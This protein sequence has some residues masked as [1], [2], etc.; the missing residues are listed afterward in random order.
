[1]HIL[2]I[3]QYFPPEM[4]A[5]AARAYEF[6]RRWVE[7]GHRVTVLCGVPNHPTGEV[8]PGYRQQWRRQETI[9][10]IEVHRMWVYVTANAGTLRRTLNY[11]SFGLTS[12][13][14]SLRIDA[15]DVCIAS[16]PQFFAGLAGTVVRR[17]KHIPLVLEVRDLW[18]DSIAA[19]DAAAGKRTMAL[20]RRIERFMYRS[21]QRIVIVSPAFRAHIERCGIPGERIDVIPNGVNTALF[22]PRAGERRHFSAFTKRF[23]VGYIGT[24]GLAHGLES[25]LAA[26]KLLSNEN[27]HFVLVGEGARKAELKRRA[28]R[29]HN[30]TFYDRRPRETVAEM[31]AELD[32][33]LVLL[34]D[35]PLFQTVI[36]SK[37]FEIMGSGIPLILGVDGQAREILDAADGGIAIPPENP[38]ALAHAILRLRDDTALRE[39][40]G[41]N[42]YRHVRE[43]YDIDVLAQKY[44][45][46]LQYACSDR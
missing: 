21:A 10:G 18:P 14:G 17:L 39:K 8:Y 20:L 32:A 29:M 26:A 45:T 13:L 4:G 46:T 44:L 7:A 27:V 11:L 35:I 37:M 22:Y 24:H 38:E 9:D 36:P 41:K 3:C 6:S 40:A 42:A 15:P 16:T 5:P 43:H 31:Y 12:V 33:A 28:E 19:V 25:L 23:L 1:M 2:Y 30:V 34:R